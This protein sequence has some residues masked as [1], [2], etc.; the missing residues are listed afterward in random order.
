M[1]FFFFLGGVP[2]AAM[3]ALELFKKVVVFRIIF[4]FV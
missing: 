2:G 3:R 4:Y 1:Y